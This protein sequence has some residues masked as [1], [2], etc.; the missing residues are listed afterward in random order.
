MPQAAESGVAGLRGETVWLVA[1]ALRFP[2]GDLAG[3]GEFCV[4]AKNPAIGAVPSC[5]YKDARVRA[6]SQ[7]GAVGMGRTWRLVPTV[8]DA[9]NDRH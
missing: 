3:L 5:I 7:V 8:T 6:C 1:H 9:L 2:S 4:I